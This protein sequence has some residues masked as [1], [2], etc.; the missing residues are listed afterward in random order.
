MTFT[1][2]TDNITVTA[3]G[4]YIAGAMNGWSDEAMMDN[5]G[6][7]VEHHEIC[8]ATYE[9]KFQNGLDGWEGHSIAVATVPS[10]C[11]RERRLRTK[12]ALPM[13]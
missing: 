2:L 6:R 12:A 11:F 7:L 4:M 9:F 1:V 3:D 8:E 10:K 13:C 5:G